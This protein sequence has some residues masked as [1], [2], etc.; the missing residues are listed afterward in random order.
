[1]N[2]VY[3]RAVERY[4][5]WE[6]TQPIEVNIEKLRQCEPPFEGENE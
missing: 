4:T 1:M 3:V 2:K 6:A 5:V